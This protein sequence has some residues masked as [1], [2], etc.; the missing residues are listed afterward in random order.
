MSS[1]RLKVG[2][3]GCG[4][5][6]RALYTGIYA[7]LADI[8]QVVAVADLVDDLAENRRQA[9]KEAYGAEAH[10]A[11]L[12]AAD[13]RSGEERESQIMK[14]E[15]AESAAAY[16]IRKYRDHEELLK[17]DE[18]QL[19]VVLTRPVMR[20]V[21]IIAG[22]EAGRH[23]YSEGP[24]AKSVEEADAIVAAVGKAG[25][26]FH[27]QVIGRYTRGSA[28]ARLAVES[29]LLGQMGSANVEKNMYRSVSYYGRNYMGRWDDE[30]GG[31]VFH[32]GRYI[33]DPFL[34][35][36]GSRIVEVFAYSG[37]ILRQIETDSISQAVVRFEN[38]AIGAI[39]FSLISH[40]EEQLAGRD[41]RIVI[42]GADASIVIHQELYPPASDAQYYQFQS[43]LAFGSM[44][45]PAV[46]EALEALRPQV[47]HIPEQVT[48]EYQ[49]RLFL[50]SIINDTEPLVP[51][52]VPYHHVELTRAIYK[53]AEER[54]P[55]TLPL[56]KG[57]PFYRF[58]GRLTGG[59]KPS[60]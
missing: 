10:R 13:A 32:H 40:T 59:V 8:A 50:E 2:I 60:S 9:L 46:L 36:V 30:G 24:L 54:Q 19:L 3:V 29:G 37:P 51:I 7:R 16:D 35:I 49:T 45:N 38:G 48:Q 28:L 26:K 17:D 34:W 15:A 52:D 14:A 27:S 22:A 12:R 4:G 39:H 33:I 44:D 25:I 57:D 47:E 58:E 21:P 55:V 18:V 20:A 31:A 53:S 56:D 11:R 42:L 5:I 43:H 23:V 41:G 1:D 6:A